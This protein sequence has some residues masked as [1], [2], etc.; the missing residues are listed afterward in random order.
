[1]VGIVTRVVTAAVVVWCTFAC[2]A[3]P[4]ASA[5]PSPRLKARPEAA[6]PAHRGMCYAS[7]PSW[8]KAP[9]AV[10]TTPQG[11]AFDPAAVDSGGIGYGQFRSAGSGGVGS[12]DLTQGSLLRFG[13]YGPQ[14][15][16]L[17]WLSHSGRWTVWVQLDSNTNPWTV[18]WFDSQTTTSITPSGRPVFGEIPLP[19]VKG[20]RVAWAQ[21]TGTEPG[22]PRADIRLVDLES[23]AAHVID[24][25]RVSSPVFMGT[26]LVW[27]AINESGDYRLKMYDSTSDRPLTTPAAL[28][29]AGSIVYLAASED[30][31]VWSDESGMLLTVWQ[32]G[33]PAV[34]RL[35]VGDN[36]HRLQFLEAD[37]PYVLWTSLVTS[38]LDLRTGTATEVPGGG[39]IGDGWF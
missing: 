17:G 18:H 5:V 39:A 16:G 1:M 15:G 35:A 12:Y 34:T 10:R 31:L 20:E 2:T 11:M 29:Q 9:S 8:L 4:H 36:H 14:V 21:P 3:P 23:G 38:L 22:I 19:A 6:S 25:G 13:A 24:S 26:T 37:G 27:A 32:A 28:Q 33:S 30:Y 7:T